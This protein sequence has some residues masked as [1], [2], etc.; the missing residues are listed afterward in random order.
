MRDY[1]YLSRYGSEQ[2]WGK[3]GLLGRAPGVLEYRLFLSSL[4]E[5]VM[6][7]YQRNPFSGPGEE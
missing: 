7:D 4:H 5:H 3:G 1:A 2:I 6:N